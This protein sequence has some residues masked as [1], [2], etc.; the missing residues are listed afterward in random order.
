MSALG[1]IGVVLGWWVL[2]PVWVMPV[3]RF[4]GAV[5]RDG[6]RLAAEHEAEICA[7]RPVGE[8]S[9]AVGGQRGAGSVEPVAVGVAG[10]RLLMHE[11]DGR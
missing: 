10:C 9:T 1:W 4:L 5:E 8:S 2:T 3:G 7:G 11:G 6:Q